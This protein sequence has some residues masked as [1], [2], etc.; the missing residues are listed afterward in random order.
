M[1]SKKNTD[2]ENS[3]SSFIDLDDAHY[4]STA[5]IGRVDESYKQHK[6]SFNSLNDFTDEEDNVRIRKVSSFGQHAFKHKTVMDA[7]VGGVRQHQKTGC[8]SKSTYVKKKKVPKKRPALVEP[9]DDDSCNNEDDICRCP[10]VHVK[11]YIE[12]KLENGIVDLND[13][14]HGFMK[15]INTSKPKV[16]SL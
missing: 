1:A 16:G 10:H 15:R 8:G 13:I 2:M 12:N 7:N 9:S 5:M 3:S 11:C 6:F 14:K 4:S